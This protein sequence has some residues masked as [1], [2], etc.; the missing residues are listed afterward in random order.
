MSSDPHVA[1]KAQTLCRRPFALA[2]GRT[3][4]IEPRHI[5]YRDDILSCVATACRCVVFAAHKD[6]CNDIDPTCPG[7]A[8]PRPRAVILFDQ[9]TRDIAALAVAQTLRHDDWLTQELLVPDRHDG[10]TP[11][12]DTDTR[13][14]LLG[15]AEEA[16][17]VLTVG[18]GVVNDLGKWIALERGVPF[19]TFPTAASMN[20]YTS[21]NVAP[22]IDGV[23]TLIRAAA[24]AAVL[25][26]PRII[27][28]APFEMTA[29]GLG[30]VLAKS[31]S[32]A[33]WRMNHLLFGDDYDQGVVDLVTDIE[34]LYMNAPADIAARKP[35]AVN[36]V[37]DALLLTGMGMTLAGTSAPASG[38]EHLVSHTLD[39]MSAIDGTPHD[40]HGRQVGVGTVLAAAVYEKVLAVESPR[41]TEPAG[42]VD[43]AFWGPMA[44][45]VAREYAGKRPRLDQARRT[46]ATGHAWDDL[47]ADLAAMIRPAR[48][49]HACL[50]HAGAA[51]CAGDIGVSAARLTD[52][53]ARAAQMRSRFTALDLAELLGILPTAA[54]EIVDQ[55]A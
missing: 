3:V 33:D 35:G 27:R 10:A 8:I 51:H 41:F 47:R 13:D 26:A 36:A 29:A 25:A 15:R 22:T 6:S 55:W 37:F 32:S 28:E 11:A 50:T 5:L 21:A 45:V 9:R 38:A 53:L 16:D 48:D 54:G 7:C 52:A 42:E 30:D 43:R 49:I 44:N 2:D 23:K 34:P 20:G 17:L 31:V 46:L 40:L 18:S 4:P 1:L 12:C 39:M 24:P 19:V 14:E